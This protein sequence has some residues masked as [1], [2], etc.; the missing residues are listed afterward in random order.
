MNPC[1]PATVA[2][3]L[4]CVKAQRLARLAAA[5]NSSLDANQMLYLPWEKSTAKFKT[6]FGQYPINR[7]TSQP[8]GRELFEK[9]LIKEPPSQ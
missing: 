5:R 4:A 1:M 8:T 9:P 2:R 7:P 3:T 6:S